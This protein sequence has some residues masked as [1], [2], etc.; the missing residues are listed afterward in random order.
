MNKNDLNNISVKGP[1]ATM[2][3]IRAWSEAVSAIFIRPEQQ[4]R[5][6][7]S[8]SG[9]WLFTPFCHFFFH[10]FALFFS[11]FFLFFY[12]IMV[13]WSL[14]ALHSSYFSALPQIDNVGTETWAKVIV[15]L[16]VALL[17]SELRGSSRSRLPP[18]RYPWP[19]WAK[20]P[21]E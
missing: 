9:S 21:G 13:F 19:R 11:F 10:I 15:S 1:M 3:T 14:E 2:N 18:L 17:W 8:D 20:L 16:E 7:M 5:V 4:Y 6:C 12:T